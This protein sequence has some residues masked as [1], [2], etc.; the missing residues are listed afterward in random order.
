MQRIVD[1]IELTAPLAKVFAYYTDLKNLLRMTPPELNL[2]VQKAETPLREGSRIILVTRHRLLPME[3]HWY[4]RITEFKM[5]KTYT[6]SLV[7]GP[8]PRWVHRHDFEELPGGRTRVTDSLEFAPA[9]GII[10]KLAQ[11]TVVH[12]AIERAYRHRERV[13]RRDLE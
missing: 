10:A 5:N 7:K 3:V 9:S 12:D 11:A 1:T 4:I 13:L 6:D 2:A 8:V